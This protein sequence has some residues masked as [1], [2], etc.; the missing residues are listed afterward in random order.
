MLGHAL[1]GIVLDLAYA[2]KDLVADEGHA[3]EDD[4]RNEQGYKLSAI[5]IWEWKI[6]VLETMTITGASM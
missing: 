1:L 4:E 2:E 3:T 6:V 5:S